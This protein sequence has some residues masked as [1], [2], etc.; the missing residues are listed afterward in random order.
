MPLTPEMLE[1]TTG[2]PNLT[3]PGS[4]EEPSAG[5]Q[6]LDDIET[7]TG[8]PE[9]TPQVPTAGTPE[10]GATQ[11]TAEGTPKPEDVKQPYT[12][13]EIVSL[14]SSGNELDTDRLSPEGKLLM[15]SFQSGF[16]SKFK[17]LSEAQRELDRKLTQSQE[18]PLTKREQYYR[19]FTQNPDKVIKEIN[20]AITELEIDQHNPDNRQAIANLRDM[21]DEFLLRKDKEARASSQATEIIAKTRADILSA[22]P[23]FD[24]KVPEL[25]TFAETLGFDMDELSFLTNPLKTGPF[26]VK[27]TKALC[28]M[29]DMVNASKT[30]EKKVDRTPP[31]PLGRSG[32]SGKPQEVDL[33]SLPQAEFEKEWNKRYGN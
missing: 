21:K 2:N 26:A 12:N 1:P 25:N 31:T 6:T 13:D 10:G 17:K 19:E 22:V 24:A 23:D 30:A 33:G 18:K 27:L 9:A 32:S 11:Q 20:A 28:K 15:R 16:D 29:H 5:N 3:P 8:E 4:G 7:T 14:L